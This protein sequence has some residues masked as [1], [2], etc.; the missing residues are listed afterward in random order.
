MTLKQGYV[1]KTI[2]VTDYECSCGCKFSYEGW[3]EGEE[4]SSVKLDGTIVTWGN[5]PKC[6]KCDSK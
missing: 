2:D 6:P 4:G 1:W 3:M 5:E